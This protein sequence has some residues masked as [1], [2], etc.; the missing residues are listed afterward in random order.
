MGGKK[1]KKLKR[2]SSSSGNEDNAVSMAE[3]NNGDESVYNSLKYSV[4]CLRSVVSEG[5]AKVHT[6]LDSLRLELKTEMEEVKLSVKEIEKSLTFTQGE[7][8]LLKEELTKEVTG[9]ASDTDALI[10]RIADLEQKLK[11]EVENNTNLEQ[12]T[13]RENLRF[14]NIKEEED[15]DCKLVVY[16]V[17]EKE[18]GINTSDMR[19][20]AAHRVGKKIQGRCRP[21]IVRFVCREDRDHVWSARGKIK[22]SS[23]HADAY[24]T[25]DYARAIQEERRVLIKAMMK[26]RE[27]HG[28][29]DAKVKGRY[30]FINNERYN[31]KNIPEFLK[32]P[33]M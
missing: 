22:E 2:N 27:E 6:D 24:I 21:I 1:R 25:E 11:K 9:R 7:V 30:L 16:D 29:N 10:K 18:L 26:A 32:Q 14:N 8:E 20:H 31:W 4:D 23:V 33:E 17:L 5:F 19:F 3:L 28:I 13:R 12:Y 15:E